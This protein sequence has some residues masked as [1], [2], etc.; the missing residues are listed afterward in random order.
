M[1]QLGAILVT[2]PEWKS[3]HI[4][5]VILF[6][7]K[8]SDRV[9]EID[10]MTKLLQIL[11]IEASLVVVSLD[12]F[13]VY[14]TIVK[15]DPISFNYVSNKLKDSKWWT[16]LTEAR[17]TLE[18]RRRFSTSRPVAV[19]PNEMKPKKYDTSKLQRM[20][21]SFKMSSTVPTEMLNTPGISDPS[22]DEDASLNESQ[23]SINQ[24]AIKLDKLKNKR[25][26]VNSIQ[27][28][29]LPPN[30]STHNLKP[31]FSSNALPNTKVLEDGTGDK[32][33]IVP[34]AED[35]VE[36]VLSRNPV[37]P[38]LS[39]C[40]S[41]ASLIEAMNNI[42]FDDLPSRAQH[43]I[44]NDMMVQLSRDSA[45]IFSTLPIPPLGTHLNEED[46]FEYVQDLDMWLERL[47]P[48]MLINSQTMTV[49]TAL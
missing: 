44:L 26:S 6:V 46:S 12:Q 31:V 35:G 17:R 30:K 36:S 19:G 18:P 16:E 9:A 42:E 20:G 33:T 10:R 14:N 1:L 7:E 29:R 5:R 24:V 2:V 4:L 25:K 23:L 49:T 47:P 45:L 43:L 34:V 15:G 39:P 48:T 3:T 22:S 27:N 40:N 13:R 21:V 38:E 32:P 8:E 11:R 41:E 28:K 37:V